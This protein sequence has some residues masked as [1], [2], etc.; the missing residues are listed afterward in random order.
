MAII[1]N[2]DGV[3]LKYCYKCKQD[4]GLV[5][6][7]KN[8]KT[9]DGYKDECIGCARAAQKLYYLSLPPERK[10]L[11]AERNRMKRLRDEY[12]LAPADF[13]LMLVTQGNKCAICGSSER[14]PEVDHCHKTN[15]VRQLLCGGCNTG[16][17][18]FNDSV[19]NMLAAVKY[20]KKH[21]V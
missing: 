13:E 18:G 2:T 5:N 14:F 17:G 1:T 21:Q 4:R 8:K 16:L 9:P 7:N 6:F 10:K 20:L 11:L 19:E 3:R 15:K 12:N